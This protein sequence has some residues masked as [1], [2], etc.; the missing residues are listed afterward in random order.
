MANENSAKLRGPGYAINDEDDAELDRIFSGKPLA[1]LS[2]ATL[3]P[4]AN[5]YANAN[6]TGDIKG[7]FT[8]TDGIKPPTPATSKTPV[9]SLNLK[10]LETARDSTRSVLGKNS[11]VNKKNSKSQT[12]LSNTAGI[13][14]IETKSNQSLGLA[15]NGN[16]KNEKP[17][18]SAPKAKPESE[19][20]FETKLDSKQNETVPVEPAES[21]SKS[22]G[23]VDKPANEENQKEPQMQSNSKQNIQNDKK[24]IESTIEPEIDENAKRPEID[25]NSK[26]P[27]TDENTKV[28][29]TD[30]N[31]KRPEIDENANDEPEIDENAK[32]PE[33]LTKNRD[34]ENR[35]SL[36]NLSDKKADDKL[37]KLV[38]SIEILKRPL[39]KTQENTES[40]KKKSE[41]QK[42]SA[43]QK[44]SFR[45]SAKKPIE[46]SQEIIGNEIKS[47]SNPIL[48]EKSE[49][50]AE[51]QEI[52]A[53]LKEK[54]R[55]MESNFEKLISNQEKKENEQQQET[56]RLKREIRQLIDKVSFLIKFQFY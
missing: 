49:K 17:T 25:E 4:N 54:L 28:S 21:L 45:I 27:E 1:K 6:A 42:E 24:P 19:R 5:A 48:I 50:V 40:L 55:K 56:I 23:E 13:Q 39:K 44:K 47:P 9:P 37:A 33:K 34:L 36:Q 20:K 52:N 26:R 31:K 2:S 7:A 3:T 16:T 53:N 29:E 41:N 32:E 18:Q 12:A 22:N 35:K 51:L 11:A 10:Q 30:E 46:T 15:V 43:D 8:P 38:E 14:S